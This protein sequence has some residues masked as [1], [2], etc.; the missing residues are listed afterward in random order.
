MSAAAW[1]FVYLL[2]L[3]ALPIIFHLALRR[4]RKKQIFSTLMFFHRVDPRLS[5]RRKLRELLLLACRVLLIALFLLTLARLTL[6][7]TGGLLGLHGQP[8]VIVIIDNSA[9]MTAAAAG[10][11]QTKLHLAIESARTLLDH[12]DSSSEA[13]VVLLVPDFLTGLDD[14]GITTDHA[15]LAKT[16]DRV[17]ATEA[18]GNPTLALTRALNLIQSAQSG[19]IGSIHVFT[20]LQETEWARS[21]PAAWSQDVS[22][23]VSVVFH[24]IP[25]APVEGANVAIVQAE[26]I[27]RRILP[28]QPADIHV[29]LRND[30]AVPAPV[31]LNSEDDQHKTHSEP[32]SLDPAQ[33]RQ[34]QL[35]VHPE[36]PG[37][38]W[39][40][41]WIEGDNFAGDNRAVVGYLCENKASVVLAGHAA[42]YG[43]LP[44]A[45]SPYEDGRFSSLQLV[46]KPVDE[47]RAHIE[48]E[49]PVLAVLTWE[50]LARLASLPRERGENWLAEFVKKGGNLAVLP[51]PTGSPL[52]PGEGAGVR[53]A[54]APAWL[55]AR[56]TAKESLA[57]DVRVDVIDKAASFWSSLRNAEGRLSLGQVFARQYQPLKFDK[58]AGYANLLGVLAASSPLGGEGGVRG[59]K[60]LLAVKNLGKGQVIVSGL[61]FD[62]Q[63]S[64]LPRQKSIVVMAQAMALGGRTREASGLYVAAGA[65]VALPAREGD[66]AVHIVSLVGDPLD[67]TGVRS[68]VPVFPRSGAYSVQLGQEAFCLS[69]RSADQEGIRRFIESGTVPAVGSMPHTIHTLEETDLTQALAAARAGLPLYLPFLLLAM[70]ALVTE[71][72]LGVPPA[73]KADSDQRGDRLS[74]LSF[75]NS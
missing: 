52:P 68:G 47:L 5:S 4:R 43:V 72:L 38:H 19:G 59:D 33:E 22:D 12:L 8:A 9:S 64:T 1:L 25:S 50:D 70:L 18:S 46:Y 56:I 3:A 13:G 40:K 73:K 17:Q 65:P 60:I 23:N 11:S 66:D 44:F 74:S 34:V 21:T 37:Y 57:K 14:A 15:A 24:R 39:V 28:R 42:D 35:L 71:S 30:G 69:V 41:I 45:L 20:D 2:P 10:N 26:L 48:R 58:D 61:A 49:K 62:P 63:W 6:H 32:V 29:L 16:L 54:D 55:G 67:W 7:A 53:A 75:P 51:R 27:G 36:S 31:L